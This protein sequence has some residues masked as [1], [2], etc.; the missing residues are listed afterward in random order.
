ME[1]ERTIGITALS[2][3]SIGVNAANKT[4]AFPCGSVVTEYNPKKNLQVDF[5]DCDQCISCVTYSPDSSLVAV[6]QRGSKSSLVVWQCASKEVLFS[7]HGHRFGIACAV[8]SADGRFIASVGYKNDGKLF[9]WDVKLQRAVARGA[10]SAGV[11][12][13]A[14]N[15]ALNAF[16]T[17]GADSALHFW[18]LA[19]IEPQLAA[20]AVAAAASAAAGS[21]GGVV[22][23]VP[24]EPTV[25][26]PKAARFGDK[27]GPKAV[28]FVDVACGQGTACETY[29]YTVTSSGLLCCFNSSRL[30]YRWVNLRVD[31]AF[32]L[33]V[34]ATRIFVGC[35]DATIRVFEP[36][37]CVRACLPACVRVCV[38]AC[39]CA[40]VRGATCVRARRADC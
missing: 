40:C 17:A 35:S 32:C 26:E 36:G 10:V 27:L 20:A 38:R 14:Y 33:D 19:D 18:Y 16:V 39:V 6:G 22:H 29:T 25:F 23:G 8:F 2:N 3:S 4:V 21:I 37:A 7:G 30:P 31:H 11:S 34:T 9:L 1:L 5:Y 15:V 12:S 28:D 13:I 24:P